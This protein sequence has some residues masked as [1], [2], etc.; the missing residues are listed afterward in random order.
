LRHPIEITQ[1]SDRYIPDWQHQT[2]HLTLIGL[3]ITLSEM[4]NCYIISIH[5]KHLKINFIHPINTPVL[6]E[7]GIIFGI[8]VMSFSILQ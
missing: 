1:T 4:Q 3:L 2:S 6:P 7:F 8:V 5:L